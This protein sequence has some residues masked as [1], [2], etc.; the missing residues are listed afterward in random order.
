V[1]APQTESRKALH[2]LLDLLREVDERWLSP[3][4]AI[5][6]PADVSDGH[7]ALMH[8]LQGGL[9]THFEDD[10]DHPLFRRIV[11]PTRKMTGDNPDAIYYDTAVSAR[12][13]YRVRG[14][15]AGA[16]YTSLTIEA[17]AAE[18]RFAS[19]T[20]GVINDGQFD[21]AAD[22]S[23]EV[24]LGGPKRPRN[25]IALPENA[26]RITT[27]HYF[28]EETSAAAN[29]AKR[30]Q[31]DIQVI[32]ETL[33]PPPTPDDARI[34]AGIR[35]VSNFVRGRT[36]E[37]PPP[38][39]RPQPPFVSTTPNQF[40]KPIKPGDFAF[41]A[42]DAAY[43]MA[44]YLL[45]PDHALVMT[46]RWPT[47]RCANVC[48]WNR[49]MQTYDYSHRTAGLNRKQTRLEKDGSFRMVLAHRDPGVPNWIDT[50]G[51]PFGMVFWRFMLP[52]GDIETPQAVL[53]PFAEIA[54][55]SA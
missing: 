24:F 1:S 31:L 3:E 17:D 8:L 28:E 30:I 35:R 23:F 39:Q 55:A 38:G 5:Q 52:E 16:V 12:H 41:A 34:A 29:P 22:G 42:A 19:G 7:R 33:P 11:S 10:P 14:N 50:E 27:R 49:W 4:W 43:S 9:Y 26:S 47:C 13:T 54:K 40:P 6:A 48:L 44:P 51:R 36:L 45:G 37:Q 32:G 2:E 53:V 46:G 25:W 21:V 20:A 15:L 18:G